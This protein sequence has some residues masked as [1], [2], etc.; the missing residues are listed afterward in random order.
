MGVSNRQQ[1]SSS[2]SLVL[3]LSGGCVEDLKKV[4]L[5]VMTMTMKDIGLVVRGW[6]NVY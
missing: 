2:L 4:T 1:N 3:Q 6:Q 5:H